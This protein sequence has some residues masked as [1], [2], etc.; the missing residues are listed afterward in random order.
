[1]ADQLLAEGGCISW[2]RYPYLAG[3]TVLSAVLPAW[4]LADDPKVLVENL[5]DPA[6]RARVRAEFQKGLDV[7]SNRSILLGWSK[8]QIS[9]VESE[10]N[11][12]MVGQDIETLAKTCEKDPVDLICD[13]LVEE[14]MAV[15]MISF[16]G[17]EPVLHKIMKHPRA[18]VGTDGI[19]GGKPHPRL[20]G[21]FPRFIEKFVKQD[22]LFTLPEAIRRISSLP[23]EI[24][25]LA[26]RGTLQPGYWADVVLLELDQVADPAT[27]AHPQQPPKGIEY[28]F[29]NGEP[30]IKLGKATGSLPGRVLRKGRAGRELS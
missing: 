23:A 13:L 21:T 14:N 17:S 1:M 15:K 7:W 5:K 25:G 30:V 22:Q 18:A 20:Y 27:Y 3:C 8:V 11:R 4:A 29:V 28:V 16:Y 2:D 24:L 19:P 9:A 26:D 12:W 6:Y 10:K